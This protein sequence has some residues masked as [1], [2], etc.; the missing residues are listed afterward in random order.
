MIQVADYNFDTKLF[1]D[2]N[3]AWGT[4]WDSFFYTMSGK[5]IWIPL[6][7]L[8]LFFIYRRWG[9]KT[10]L[11]SLVFIGLSVGI[12]DQVCNLF[13]DGIEKL[14]P[15]HT[16]AIEHL[17]HTVNGYRGG[18]Y[19]TFSAHAATTTAIATFSALVIRRK[20]FSILIPLWVIVVSYSRIYL[21]VHFPAD[22]AC[23]MLTGIVIAV[24]AFAL[25]KWQRIRKFY[26]P[27][28]A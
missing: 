15:T 22:I 20:L 24:G 25:F 28:P 9:W 13:K 7:L 14:R 12:A 27:L 8:I 26:S 4:G 1:L 5:L 23:G 18:L 6:Y 21:G 10:M 19:G 17:V 11:A 16:P 3:G 2:L